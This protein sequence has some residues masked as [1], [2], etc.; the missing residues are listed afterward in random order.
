MRQSTVV[1]RIVVAAVLGSAAA[2]MPAGAADAAPAVALQDLGTLGGDWSTP[3]DITDSGYVTGNSQTATGTVHGFRWHD[4]TLTDLGTLGTDSYA[5]AATESGDVA[6]TYVTTAGGTR[7]FRWRDGVMTD[8]TAVRGE[9]ASVTDI[10]ERGM[11]IGTR[12]TASTGQYGQAYVW[13]NGTARDLPGRGGDTLA[14]AINDRGDIAGFTMT[15]DGTGTEAAIWRG[16]R[17]TRITP[18]SGETSMASGINERGQVIGTFRAEGSGWHAF[19]WQNGR[20]TDLGTLGGTQ[21]YPTGINDRGQI[22]GNAET[23]TALHPVRWHRGHITDLGT[24]LGGQYAQTAAI[25]AAGN[26]A[27][28]AGTD[29]GTHGVVWTNDGLIDLGRIDAGPTAGLVL[30]MNNRGLVTGTV[31]TTGAGGHA[32]VWNT[33]LYGARPASST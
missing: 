23:T 31:A 16:G 7:P 19:L 21:S 26:V 3:V 29:D 4:G 18:P 27:G 20:A 14:T 6:G 24:P 1:S 12:H 22:S 15:P 13:H 28:Q 5:A 32:V 10:N 2:M 11:I 8:L 25:D 33:R 30:A 9:L 17:L